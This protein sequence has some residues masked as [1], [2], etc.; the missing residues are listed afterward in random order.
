MEKIDNRK[1][2]RKAQIFEEIKMEIWQQT[3]FVLEKLHEPPSFSKFNFKYI[4]QSVKTLKLNLS[5][6]KAE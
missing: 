5:W 3:N 4:Q 1:K 2:I 6:N